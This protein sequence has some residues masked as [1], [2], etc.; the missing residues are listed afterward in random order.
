MKTL[1]NS[2]L[3]LRINALLSGSPAVTTKKLQGL[4]NAAGNKYGGN[5]YDHVTPLLQD[6]LHWL[7][8]PERV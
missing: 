6:K 5:K 8:V 7:R 4:L 3:V 2:L 1:A